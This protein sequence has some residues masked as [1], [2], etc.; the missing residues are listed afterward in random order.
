MMVPGGGTFI[1]GGGNPG[2]GGG[3]VRAPD[4]GGGGN[5]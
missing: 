4:T 3:T 2:R 1:R 5:G